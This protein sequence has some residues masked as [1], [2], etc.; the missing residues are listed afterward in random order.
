VRFLYRNSTDARGALVPYPLFGSDQAHMSFKHFNATM[1]S[2]GIANVTT[3]CSVCESNTFFCAAADPPPVRGHHA[4]PAIV[5][6]GAALAV[7]LFIILIVL[8]LM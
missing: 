4:W 5:L 2:I 1:W 6:G 3:W 7:V 8:I